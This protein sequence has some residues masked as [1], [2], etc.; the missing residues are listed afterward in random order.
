M[1]KKS[2]VWGALALGVLAMPAAQAQWTGKGEAGYLA[3]K[4][5]AESTA[6]NV[7]LDLAREFGDWKHAA[8]LGYLV[9]ENKAFKNAERVEGRWQTDRNFTEKLFWFGALRGEQD[10]FSGFKYQASATTGVGYKFIENDTTKLTGTLG[11]GYRRLE[12]ETLVKSLAGE[13]TSRTPGEEESD[14]IGTAGLDFEHQL[15]DTTKL[16][17]RLLVES[18]SANT[19]VLND[20]AVLVSVTEAVGLSVGYGVRYNAEPPDGATSTDRVTTVNL[21]YN[22]K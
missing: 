21:V 18:G 3:S 2:N 5:N 13:V 17:N 1:I 4:G 8:F 16:L 22:I 20:F 6:A 9:G 7:K 14:A 12:T 11:A 15:T 19:S 10:R